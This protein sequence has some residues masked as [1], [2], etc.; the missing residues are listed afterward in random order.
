MY[1]KQLNAVKHYGMIAESV[2]RQFGKMKSSPV[3]IRTTAVDNTLT[4]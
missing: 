1:T 3:P 2:R 4:G